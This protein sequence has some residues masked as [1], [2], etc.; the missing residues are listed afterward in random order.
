MYFKLQTCPFLDSDSEFLF[1]C[2]LEEGVQWDPDFHNW[3]LAPFALGLFTLNTS[4]RLSSIQSAYDELIDQRPTDFFIDKSAAN[5]HVL[6]T[7]QLFFGEGDK[8]IFGSSFLCSSKKQ[9][10]RTPGCD[11]MNRYHQFEDF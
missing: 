7:T 1:Q 3:S 8:V 9:Q 10:P 4:F 11:S 5:L 6:Y 2:S